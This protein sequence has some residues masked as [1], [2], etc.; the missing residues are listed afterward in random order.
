LALIA[1]QPPKFFTK[2]FDDYFILNA[3]AENPLVR[4]RRRLQRV[5]RCRF[6]QSISEAKQTTNESQYGSGA[7]SSVLT[8]A[9]AEQVGAGSI[10]VAGGSKYQE[11]GAL[12]LSH[13][14]GK[15][16]TGLDLSG[17]SN[18]NI[19]DPSTQLAQASLA[20]I[21]GALAQAQQQASN[22]TETL[23]NAL[24]NVTP[25]TGNPSLQPSLLDRAT[26]WLQSF[27]LNWYEVVGVIAL[28]GLLVV[29]KRKKSHA[30]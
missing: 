23:D 12:D 7:G 19:S 11:E 24:A 9:N 2:M 18:I 14:S 10:G 1:A 6:D 25:S 17:A 16:T 27:G 15:I 20:T 5:T 21:S 4:S 28:L 3:C 29:F 26:G 30:K 13:S 8:G 22:A